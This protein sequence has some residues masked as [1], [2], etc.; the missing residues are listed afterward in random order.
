MTVKK[1]TGTPMPMA[2]L[3][4]VLSPLPSPPG[5]GVGTAVEPEDEVDCIGV[6]GVVEVFSVVGG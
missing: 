6:V 1:P 2:I 5:D 3:S 4:P